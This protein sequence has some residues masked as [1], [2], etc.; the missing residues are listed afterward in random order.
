MAPYSSL[1]QLANS[2]YE[3][4]IYGFFPHPHWMVFL[5]SGLADIK[6]SVIS[7]KAIQDSTRRWDA[8]FRLD[9][10]QSTALPDRVDYV[11]LAQT[12]S[13]HSGMAL[14]K[15][16]SFRLNRQRDQSV[17][18]HLEGPDQIGFLGRLL[19]QASLLALFPVE[20]EV[21]TVSSHIQD[22]IVFRGFG[23]LPPDAHVDVT[24]QNLLNNLLQAR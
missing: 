23:G 17:E 22:R 16:T 13:A 12:K 11:A 21:S 6:V 24:L 3:L 1:S 5:F 8:T 2:S 14:P 18:V 10:T 4:S 20:M 9:F 15:L 7:G 19:S